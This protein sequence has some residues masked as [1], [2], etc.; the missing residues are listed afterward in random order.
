M[1]CLVSFCFCALLS[2][3]FLCQSIYLCICTCVIVTSVRIFFRFRIL[4]KKRWK[5]KFVSSDS[6]C[7]CVCVY[8]SEKRNRSWYF[9]ACSCSCWFLL[10]MLLSSMFVALNFIGVLLTR[11]E[12]KSCKNFINNDIDGKMIKRAISRVDDWRNLDLA[13]RSCRS[14]EWSPSGSPVSL[15]STVDSY[16]I[17]TCLHDGLVL[18]FVKNVP[19]LLRDYFVKAQY[20]GNEQLFGKTAIVTGANT[21]IGK[22]V[23]HD[24]ARRGMT[25]IE[26]IDVLR[27]SSRMFRCS[28]D[29]GLSW[30]D[31]MWTDTREDRRWFLQ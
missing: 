22:E 3:S 11:I 8:R 4:A 27:M 24:F 15:A 12:K 1:M 25:N 26:D 23:A 13:F 16:S 20:K 31:E 30:S 28:R 29:H 2:Q 6:P 17:G 18:R 9:I 5:K 7:L 14:C 21:G 10:L 19:S